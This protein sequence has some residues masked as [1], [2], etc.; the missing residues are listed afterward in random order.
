MARITHLPPEMLVE[1]EK[2]LS[3]PFSKDAIAL[4][5]TCKSFWG[6]LGGNKL[7]VRAAM[8]DRD[9]VREAQADELARREA[10]LMDIEEGELIETDD[11]G[12]DE[13][14]GAAMADTAGT[15]TVDLPEHSPNPDHPE[16]WPTFD[17]ATRSCLNLAIRRCRDIEKVE[18]IVS[19]YLRFVPTVFRGSWHLLEELTPIHTAIRARRFDMVQLLFKK[20]LAPECNDTVLGKPLLL[21]GTEGEESPHGNPHEGM[22]QAVRFRPNLFNV[23][24]GARAED[25]CLFLLENSYELRYGYGPPL[26]ANKITLYLAFAQEYDMYRLLD[27]LLDH[28]KKGLGLRQYQILLRRLLLA[29]PNEGCGYLPVR[30]LPRDTWQENPNFSGPWQNRPLEDGAYILDRLLERGAGNGRLQLDDPHVPLD[31]V[32]TH[33]V[34][35]GS[36]WTAT[37]ILRHQ[38]ATGTVDV[39]DLMQALEDSHCHRYDSL[40]FF[41][42]VWS[43]YK[44]VLYRDDLSEEE[45]AQAIKACLSCCMG[46]AM[47]AEAKPEQP[48][49]SYSQLKTV[50]K[51]GLFHLCCAIRSRQPAIVNEF[52]QVHGLDPHQEIETCSERV[53]WMLYKG[54]DRLETDFAYADTPF[55]VAVVDWSTPMG[56]SPSLSDLAIAYRLVY[57]GGAPKS[58]S[59]R[60]LDNLHKV[61]W[62]Y[63]V[64]DQFTYSHG[65]WRAHDK[66]R[67]LGREVLLLDGQETDKDKMRSALL[68]FF[69]ELLDAVE[70][71]GDE[72]KYFWDLMAMKSA[73]WM[74]PISF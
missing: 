70:E 15:D 31:L 44:Q 38:I 33:A 53:D 60:M 67:R 24:L 17:Q 28:F 13:E 50:V 65:R 62:D 69:R 46:N 26:S 25:I 39:E 16:G 41:R 1:I 40:D 7:Y 21:W 23:A 52:V 58:W 14:T 51:P 19:L 55:E 27:A 22:K 63:R 71:D 42:T 72:H 59:E 4:S 35:G 48:D 9:R 32:L 6:N 29:I 68:V 37:R 61:W 49:S 20:G 10:Q 36:I 66:V 57:H 45:N 3:Y 8:G 34:L 54:D 43:N 2:H 73:L 64:D 18:L 47:A 5:S 12:I 74:R 30:L 11:A 56:F